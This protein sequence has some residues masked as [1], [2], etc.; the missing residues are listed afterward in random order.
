VQALGG[1]A[2]DKLALE[3]GGRELFRAL[4][5]RAAPG[6]VISVEGPNG[7][8]KTSLLRVLAGFL[9]QAS[10]T[11]T[12]TS[13]DGAAIADAEERGAFVGWLGHQDG[14]KPQLTPFETLEFFS[15]F[16]GTAC[17]SA[18]A[19]EEVGLVRARDLPAQYLS[20]GQKKRVALARLKLSGR[21]LWLLD[22]PLASLDAAGKALAAKFI[23]DHCKAGGIAIA[24]THEPLG[25]ECT[26]LVLGGDP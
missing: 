20:A 12:L 25:I 15:R 3:R 7:A 5:F 10:G 17:D 23:A 19:L 9:Q 24:A 4:A 26:R 8:G 2:A 6:D 1:F 16:Y 22:E 11:I 21:P 13:S 18:A 14:V